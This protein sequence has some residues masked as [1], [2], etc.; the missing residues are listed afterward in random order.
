VYL[1]IKGGLETIALFALDRQSGYDFRTA[2]LVPPAGIHRKE[3]YTFHDLVRV[4]GILRGEGGC[5][6]DREQTHKSLAQYLIEESYEVLEAI[7]QDDMEKLADELGDVLLQVVFHAQIGKEYAKFDIQDVITCVCTKMIRRHTH[8]FGADIAETPDAVVSNWEAIKKRQKGIA[9]HTEVLKDI[10]AGMPALM[11]GCKVQKKAALV[12]FDWPDLDG[13]MDKIDEEAAELK[14]AVADS[15]ETAALENEI[16]DLLFAV[17]NVA[18]KRKIQPELALKK[19][20]D[21]FIARFKYMEETAAKKGLKI[22][23]MSLNDM[24]TLWEEAKKKRAIN[25]FRRGYKTL[26][27]GKNDIQKGSLIKKIPKNKQFLWKIAG[28]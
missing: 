15:A 18:R 8:I 6:W 19:S 23:N 16:G 7:E 5:P 22:E 17:V 25:H 28:I 14:Q 20:I 12:G 2:L 9:T 24:D 27:Y 21:K 3:R 1:L 11:R 10:P 4:M 13:A 26:N